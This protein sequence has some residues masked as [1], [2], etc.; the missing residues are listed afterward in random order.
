MSKSGNYCLFVS[1]VMSLVGITCAFNGGSGRLNDPYRISTPEHLI[2]IGSNPNLLEKHFIM[3][4][5]VNMADY[6]FDTAVIAPDANSVSDHHQGRSFDGTFDGDGHKIMNLTFN[7]FS[8]SDPDN[9]NNDYLG[10]F[11]RLE[12]NSVVKN[13]GIQ[14]FTVQGGNS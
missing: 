2:S 11:G 4:A 1:V 6:V 10:L 7:L 13:L 3:V 9:D 5:D 12:D 14:T 8:D